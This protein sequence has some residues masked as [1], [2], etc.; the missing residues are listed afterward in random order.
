MKYFINYLLI[1]IFLF[2]P[3]LINAHNKDEF[4]KLLNVTKANFK[5]VNIEIDTS[6]SDTKNTYDSRE[7][8]EYIIIHYVQC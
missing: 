5:R 8:I 6:Y 4:S 7:K 2:C 3:G 1:S